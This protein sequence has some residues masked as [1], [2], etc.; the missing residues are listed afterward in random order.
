MLEIYSSVEAATAVLDIVRRKVAASVAPAAHEALL[1]YSALPPVEGIGNP[2]RLTPADPL[3][4]QAIVVEAGIR[5]LSDFLDAFAAQS[6]LIRTGNAQLRGQPGLQALGV[7]VGL[8]EILEQALRSLEICCADLDVSYAARVEGIEYAAREVDA[9]IMDEAIE[10]LPLVRRAQQ[11]RDKDSQGAPSEAL[12]ARRAEWWE[13]AAVPWWRSLR[14]W[15]QDGMSDADHAGNWLFPALHRA[16]ERATA[17]R[18][19]KR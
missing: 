15:A 2:P 17:G 4:T 11:V 1:L 18:R 9:A 6:A 13:S 8:R 3:M 12:T 16:G 14:A 19:R 7:V 10:L 5:A